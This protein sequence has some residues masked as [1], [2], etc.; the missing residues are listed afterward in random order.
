MFVSLTAALC[1]ASVAHTAFS[2]NQLLQE[3]KLLSDCFLSLS[4]IQ[5]SFNFPCVQIHYVSTRKMKVYME[6][7]FSEK[8]KMWGEEEESEEDE[9]S[10]NYL[11]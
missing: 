7:Y 6:M 9:A 2:F 11:L 8:E 1:S 4:L 10:H 3:T 5:T